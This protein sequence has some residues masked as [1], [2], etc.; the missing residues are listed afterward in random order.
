M[1]RDYSQYKHGLPR[2][3][4]DM[5]WFHHLYCKK[6]AKGC[7]PPWL[8]MTPPQQWERLRAFIFQ[9]FTLDPRGRCMLPV[10]GEKGKQRN[11]ASW[12]GFWLSDQELDDIVTQ[13]MTAYE[14]PW[15]LHEVA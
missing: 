10:P 15:P 12:P 4:Y 6:F 11:E 5:E 3:S 14:A 2:A 13:V 7:D 8:Q 9:K 1:T